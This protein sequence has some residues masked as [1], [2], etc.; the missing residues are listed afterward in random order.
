MMVALTS[1]LETASPPPPPPPSCYNGSSPS[2]PGLTG[3][4]M[5][6]SA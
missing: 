3:S 6:P 1:S 5:A 2:Q 4:G